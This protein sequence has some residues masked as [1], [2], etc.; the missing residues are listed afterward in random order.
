MVITPT[1]NV[2]PGA[3]L[4]ELRPVVEDELKRHLRQAKEWLPYQYIPF[5]RGEDYEGAAGGRAWSPEQATISP[6]IAAAIAVN[7]LTEDN[8]PSYHFELATLY[9]R[10]GPWGEWVHRGTAEEARHSQAI[11]DYLLVSRACDPVTLE[12]E[13]MAHMSNGFGNSHPGDPLATL[14]YVS[15]QELATRVSHRN[16]SGAVDDFVGKQ[17]FAR[18]AADENLHM[19]FYRSML[20]AALDLAP[21]QTMR[22]IVRVVTGFRMPGHDLPAFRRRAVQIALAGIYDLRQHL[23]RVLMPVL[24]HW[25]V[26][27]RPLGPSGERAREALDLFLVDLDR[28]ASRFEERRAAHLARRAAHS[29]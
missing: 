15:F 14:A 16:V 12:R 22:A 10:G 25:N 19:L 24:C 17:L 4:T 9:G 23:D 5:G 21:E 2:Q 28:Q 8:L 27:D 13:R 26:W 20:G 18:I 11:R 29:N 3:L 7:L 6:E 1:R